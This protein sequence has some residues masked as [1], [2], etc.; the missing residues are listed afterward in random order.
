MQ[1]LLDQILTLTPGQLLKRSWLALLVC[2]AFS[3]LPKLEGLAAVLG[4]TV[5]VGYPLIVILSLSNKKSISHK[6]A[7]LL[8]LVF[9]ACSLVLISGFPQVFSSLIQT[10][11]YQLKNSWAVLVFMILF[12]ASIFIPLFLATHVLD[13]ARQK[14]G[15]YKPLDFIPTFLGFYFGIFG[16]MLYVHRL[17]RECQLK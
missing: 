2:S 10:G 14:N 7:R 8:A 3:G 9:I 6:I 17:V 11:V 1:K 5:F 4:L 15:T 16:G 13:V 12:N